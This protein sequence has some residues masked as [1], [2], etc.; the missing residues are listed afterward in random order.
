M[1]DERAI[2]A[3]SGRV[4]EVFETRLRHPQLCFFQAARER[5]VVAKEVFGIDEHAEALV[6]TETGERRV[7]LVREIRVG[8]V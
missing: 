3:P 5:A 1:P 4:I 8:Q 6:E 7:L 2:E